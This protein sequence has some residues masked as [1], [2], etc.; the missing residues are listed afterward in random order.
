M[1]VESRGVNSVKVECGRCALW[2]KTSE[3]NK[4]GVGLCGFKVAHPVGVSISS[5]PTFENEGKGCA[6]FI[7]NNGISFSEMKD[8]VL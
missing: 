5:N 3:H 1:T 4:L 2:N 8:V 7:P 6:F